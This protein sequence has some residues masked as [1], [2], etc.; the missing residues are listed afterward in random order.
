MGCEPGMGVTAAFHGGTTGGA[1]LRP[2]VQ[3]NCDSA[4][5]LGETVQTVPG[6]ARQVPHY[7][8]TVQSS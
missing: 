3:W 2:P 8:I 4:G 6:L 7:L 1:V 5:L